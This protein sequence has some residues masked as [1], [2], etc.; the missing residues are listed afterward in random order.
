MT[1]CTL[2]PARPDDVDQL[3][4]LAQ[5]VIRVRYTPF[6]GQEMVDGYINS[7]DANGEITRNLT[8]LVVAEVEDVILGFVVCFD[9]LV[10]LLMTRLDQQRDGVGSHLLAHAEDAI[11]ARGYRS[12]RLETFTANS[13]ARQ[14]YDKAGWQ[15]IRFGDVEG[16]GVP[17]VY[18]EKGL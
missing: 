1:D 15:E 11:A 17:L 3:C 10:H 7:G 12:A 6:L 16:L 13:Q 5:E 2:R 18:L 9:D 8:H 14:F 4:T